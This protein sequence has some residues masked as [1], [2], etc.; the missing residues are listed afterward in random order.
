MQYLRPLLPAV[1]LLAAAAICLSQN[2]KD[3][4]VVAPEKIE[5]IKAALPEKTPTPVKAKHNILVFTKTAGFRHSSIPVGVECLKQLGDKTGLFSTTHSEDASAFET[6]SLKNYDAVVFLNTTNEVFAGGEPGTEDRLK[7]NLLSFVK[8]G[9]GLVGIH[10]AT[11]TY[12]DWKEFNEMMGGAFESHPWSAG[13]TVEVKNLAPDHPLTASFGGKGFTIKDEIYKF[14][15]QTAQPEGRRM[16]L[17][18][19]TGAPI[20]AKDDRDKDGKADRDFYPIAWLSKYGEGKTFYCSLGHN[21]EVY[22]N[23]PVVAHYLAG[24]Q[25]ALGELPADA[26]PQ[27]VA[28]VM[29]DGSLVAKR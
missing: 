29:S 21:D 22:M 19:D 5:K 14:R 2:A 12:K 26:T 1:G 9:K 25:Y 8:G 13:D 15:P 4:F 16:L 24:L 10:A 28:M 6:E 18:L 3:S 27:K 11:D 20:I 17:A 23:A 7:A